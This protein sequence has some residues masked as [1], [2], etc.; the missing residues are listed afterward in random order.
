MRLLFSHT[1]FPAQFRRLLPA[2]IAEGHEVVFLCAQKEWHAPPDLD[3]LRLFPYK[4]HRVSK[5]EFLHPYLRRFE[6]VVLSGQAAFRSAIQLKQEG[7]EPDFIV[8]HI[9]FGSGLYL[10]DCFPKARKIGCIEWFYRPYGSDVDFLN[11]GF[12]EDD[13]KLRLRTWNAQLLLEAESCECL[14]TPTQWQWQQLPKDLQSRTKIIHEGIDFEHLAAL[15]IN[16]P[17]LIKSLPSS[18][19]IEWVTYVS[20]GF[21]QY[22]GFPQAMKALELIQKRRP[23]VHIAIAGSDVV[24]YG[25]ARDDGRSWKQWAEEDLDLDPLRTHWLGSIQ[26]SDYHALLAHSQAHLYITVPFVLSWSLLEAMAAACPIVSSSTPPVQEV[27]RDKENALLVD[28]WDPLEQADALEKL[29]SSPEYS[30]KM[31]Q[32]AS[33][34]AKQYAFND[35]FKAWKSLLSDLY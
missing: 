14:V 4:V 16:P 35:S 8:S 23:K 34:A 28:F 11:N 21:E 30:Y 26:E 1:N 18:T 29:L 32:K 12:V 13:R 7:W 25:S 17:L 2:L 5:P 6:E 3:G 31:G 15:K 22:R 9:G 33:H 20:R 10:P 27:L 24:A 19:E